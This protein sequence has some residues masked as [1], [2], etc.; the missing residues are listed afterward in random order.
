MYNIYQG[1]EAD[2]SFG[3]AKNGF[4]FTSRLFKVTI[5]SD[6]QTILQSIPV[7]N[8]SYLRETPTGTRALWLPN[9]LTTGGITPPPTRLQAWV[10]RTSGRVSMHDITITV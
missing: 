5:V 4:V 3:Y 10:S 6:S 9:N 1:P 8:I 2:T 7:N